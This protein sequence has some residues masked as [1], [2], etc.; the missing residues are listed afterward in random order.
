MLYEIIILLLLS[1]SEGA[2]NHLLV[3]RILSNAFSCDSGVQLMHSQ[4]VQ[5]MM[6]SLEICTGSFSFSFSQH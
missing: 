1:F 3:F 4:R 2:K 5:V 6:V